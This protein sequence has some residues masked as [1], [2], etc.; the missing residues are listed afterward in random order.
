MALRFER[1]I[2]LV[3][4]VV[5]LV[6][7]VLGF[8]FYQAT[9]SARDIREREERTRILLLDLESVVAIMTDADADVRGFI[10]T[11]NS[12]YSDRFASKKRQ[13]DA[14][15]S[16]VE[17][18]FG[19]ASEISH[20][21][22]KL[23]ASAQD[24]WSKSASK[25]ERRKIEGPAAAFT[26]LSVTETKEPLDNFRAAANELKAFELNAAAERAA[27]FDLRLRVSIWVLILSVFAGIASLILANFLV[28]SEGKRRAL[29]E[30]ELIE[31]NKD[32]EHRV[33]I[34][35]E[36]LRAMNDEL[37][38]AATEREDLL[39][40]ERVAREDAEIANRVRDEFMAAVSHELR[41]PLN[42]I[43]GWAR[44]LREGNLEEEQ[45]R[46][47]LTT[48][49][50]NSELQ[51][52]LI[53]DL[54]DVARIV[55]GK[56]QIENGRVAIVEVVA[57]AADSVRP[58][59]EAKRHELVVNIQ[60][61]SDEIALNGDANRLGQV[62]TNLLANAI[63]FTPDGGRIDL[64]LKHENGRVE[65]EV[66]DT[67]I[68]ISEEFLPMVF[69]KFRQDGSSENQ[70]GLGL[71]LAIVRN[72]VELHGGSVMAISKGRGH[73][74]TFRVILPTAETSPE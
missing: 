72:I 65:I 17:Q 69:E 42:S 59:A 70:K 5:F 51:N 49:I 1:K 39:A 40:K 21:V 47:A 3:L 48:I 45:S 29:A 9:A 8:F 44:L 14:I 35:T 30:G 57:Q 53:E 4:F 62:V 55:S 33:E 73:G 41:T 19:Q 18:A 23:S 71:G 36:E 27:E 7:A 61:G 37:T 43:L 34:R 63:K 38:F 10:L 11:G 12:T 50:K 54:L 15:Q 28:F 60:E 24:F 26:E 68:G 52:K 25:I 13:S 31:V 6:F 64:N 58:S 66:T 74:T 32:L 2:P 56:L 67:G 46:K 16:R 20:L 22:S